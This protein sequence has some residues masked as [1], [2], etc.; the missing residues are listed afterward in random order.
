MTKLILNAKTKTYISDYLSSPG[1]AIV[2]I[3]E[4]WLAK[5]RIASYIA[6]KVLEIPKDSLKKYPYYLSANSDLT[7]SITIEDIRVINDFLMLK[8]PKQTFISRVVVINRADRMTLEAQNALLKNLEEPPI[9]T[10]FILTAETKTALLPTIISRLHI[11]KVDKPSK[12]DL[13][14]YFIEE[15]YQ[16]DAIDQALLISDG[17]PALMEELLTEPDNP[18]AT[19][20]TT[21][22]KL[23]SSSTFERL[24][25]IDQLSK[26]KMQ[27]KNVLFVIKQMS[28]IGLNS[29]NP[30]SAER[31]K[32][33]LKATTESEEKL[34]TNAQTKLVL[35]N[36]M[37]SIS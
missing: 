12:A 3:G 35:T 20:A 24:S 33:I 19:A 7:S 36:Y 1:Q 17:L 27:L 32:K 4:K 23:L 30:K 16:K 34:S 26:D 13:S 8:V 37:L 5:D 18:I 21:A 31:W 25:S 22:R 14:N 28:K 15:G 29:D 11:I 9:D 6:E 10:L 2:L